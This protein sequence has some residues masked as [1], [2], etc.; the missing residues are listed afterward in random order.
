VTQCNTLS[1]NFD[2]DKKTIARHGTQTITKEVRREWLG[3]ASSDLGFAL[4]GPY[5]LTFRIQL[6]T[7]GRRHRR[8]GREH[9]EKLECEVDY[10]DKR[11]ER[12]A[13]VQQRVMVE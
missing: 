13:N 7:V 1:G 9:W 4:C 5:R 10:T 3:R 12:P 6:G 2:R 11:D 8:R